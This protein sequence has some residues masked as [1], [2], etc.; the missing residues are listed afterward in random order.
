MG[1]NKP[2]RHEAL[3][4]YSLGK[5]GLLLDAQLN[6]LCVLVAACFQYVYTFR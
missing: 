3:R 1:K 5:R 2:A 6:T 4:V